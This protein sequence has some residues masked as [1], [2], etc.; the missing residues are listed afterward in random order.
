MVVRS[1]LSVDPGK[2]NCGIVRYDCDADR[3][4]HA[5]LANLLCCCTQNPPELSKNN[6]TK[7]GRRAK[8]AKIHIPTAF[9]YP[10]QLDRM[11]RESPELFGND[12]MLVAVE[13]QNAQDTGNMV[14]QAVFQTRYSP[15]A[16]LQVPLEVKTFWNTVT[17][18]AGAKQPAFRLSGSHDINKTDA[19]RFGPRFLY[20]EELAMFE[21][22]A[23]AH[24]KHK[25]TCPVMVYKNR[26]GKKRKQRPTKTDD[27]FDAALQAIRAY[28]RYM[29]IDPSDPEGP[30]MKRV[31]RA[32]TNASRNKLDRWIVSK[33]A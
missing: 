22:A 14:T 6:E 13:R 17:D 24:A 1:I 28:H 32:M 10:S 20:R 7:K 11:F 27:L 23:E 21:T 2:E 12:L 15:L 3:F 5:V 19:R 9:E 31:K 29:A 16:E 26:R 8:T 4:T 30:A 33:K 18:A 25:A